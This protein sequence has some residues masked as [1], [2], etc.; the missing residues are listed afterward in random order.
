MDYR[1]YYGK[2]RQER[3][4]REQR[5]QRSIIAREEQEV[6]TDSQL[7]ISTA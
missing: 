1:G 6:S 3:I 5:E 2:E 7:M 4:Q